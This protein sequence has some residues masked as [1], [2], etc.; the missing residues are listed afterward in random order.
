MLIAIDT[1][2]TGPF[3][4]KGCQPFM[5]ISCT[6]EGER[7]CWEFPVNPQTRQVKY[8][9]KLLK[10]M[11]DYFMSFDGYI[12]HNAKFDIYALEHTGINREDWFAGP[13][14]DTMLM[15]HAFKSDNRHGLKELGILYLDILDDDKSELEEAV[16]KCRRGKWY[17]DHKICIATKENP[18]P[19]LVGVRE[20]HV[21][22]DY[23]LPAAYAEIENLPD[24]HPFRHV[25]FNYGIQDAERTVALFQFFKE[26]MEPEQY[27]TY[28]QEADCLLPFINIETRGTRV[29]PSA[30][31]AARQRLL[32]E[33]EKTIVSLQ[34]LGGRGD[35]NPRST[36]QLREIIYHKFKF[37]SDKV[38]KSGNPATN[39]ETL[40][41]LMGGR[42]LKKG[43]RLPD[44]YQFVGNLLNLSKINT[45]LA[46]LDNYDRFKDEDNRLHTSIRQANTGTGR[47]SSSDPS[48]MNVGKNKDTAFDEH[49]EKTFSLRNV[50]GPEKG[51]RWF[52]IDYD[53]FQLRIFAYVSENEEL[54]EGFRKGKLDAHHATACRLFNTS[55]PTEAQRKAAKYVNFGILFGAGPQRID[56]LAGIAGLY[57]HFLSQFPGARRY[58][59]RQSSLARRN[60]YIHT[61]D[62][63][64]LHV[65]R[66]QPY[67]A[68]CYVIQG[69]EARIFKRAITAVHHFLMNTDW[70]IIMPIHDELVIDA[71]IVDRKTTDIYL[72]GI[73]NRMIVSSTVHGIPAVVDAKETTTNWAD[74]KPYSLAL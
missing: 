11:R 36:P 50:F 71:P 25:C 21:H 29:I 27:E 9:R 15:S 51:R 19:S 65:P 54:L 61:V 20:G 42:Q 41:E 52:S 62:G 24:D 30:L 38:T 1:E 5:I 32:I 66:S 69:T 56:Q 47:L 64:R 16:K 2:T 3:P 40:I 34:K 23:W 73:M 4:A 43:R 55:S 49:E 53:Q 63:Y 26:A 72:R 18:H 33:R 6:E 67:A 37:K 68:S 22:C 14:H 46:Y 74:S 8:D 60:G 13:V 31:S 39:R 10:S 45:T 17:K 12:F 44:K 58:L 7:K 57:D 59:T 48:I 70:H 35:F 28:L